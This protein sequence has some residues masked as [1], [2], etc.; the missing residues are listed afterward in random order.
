MDIKELLKQNE[1]VQLVVS[2]ADLKEFALSLIEDARAME[3]PQRPA[4]G[5]EFLTSEEVMRI[6]RVKK[7]TL[8]RWAKEKY[9]VPV[10][11]GKSNLYRKSDVQRITE[12]GFKFRPCSIANLEKN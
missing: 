12:R 1:N 8:W 4:K 5:D 3:T 10:K 11:V 7:V 2:A 9:L 6:V